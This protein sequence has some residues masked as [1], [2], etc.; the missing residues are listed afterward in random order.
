MKTYLI[1]R[2]C[3]QIF[4]GHLLVLVWKDT[5]S[6]PEIAFLVYQASVIHRITKCLIYLYGISLKILH[7]KKYSN[8]LMLMGFS[9]L[10]K[11]P[12]IQKDDLPEC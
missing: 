10:T 8:G 9:D 12:I 3:P 4:S 6:E 1:A 11:Y 5:Y 7:W 2:V